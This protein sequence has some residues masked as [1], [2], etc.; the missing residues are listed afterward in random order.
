MKRSIRPLLAVLFGVLALGL[1]VIAI[2]GGIR[3]VRPE[4]M[5]MPDEVYDALNSRQFSLDGV[6][7]TL[8]LPVQELMATGWEGYAGAPRDLKRAANPLEPGHIRNAWLQNDSTA[9]NVLE[10]SFLEV[11]FFNFAE[12]ALPLSEVH[13]V[14]ISPHRGWPDV[15]WIP[16]TEIVFPGNVV[17]GSTR[18]EVLAALGTPDER[19]GDAHYIYSTEHAEMRIIF[20]NRLVLRMYLHYLGGNL[21]AEH[22]R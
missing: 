12:E 7:Y 16:D 13:I 10:I 3:A 15:G 17:I 14:Q 2:R 20:S 22:N 4:P 8:P 21:G 9:E 5:E 1:I 6:T 19:R 18:N 11:Y